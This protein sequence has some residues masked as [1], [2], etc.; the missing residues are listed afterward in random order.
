M[1]KNANRIG[2]NSQRSTLKMIKNAN[3]IGN[4]SY[5]TGNENETLLQLTTNGKELELS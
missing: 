5:R 1:I 4:N 2:N 3:R